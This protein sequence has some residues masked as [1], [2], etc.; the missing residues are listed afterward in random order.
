METLK[1]NLV[2]KNKTRT[3]LSRNSFNDFKVII[4]TFQESPYYIFN[5]FLLVT[6]SCSTWKRFIHV[7]KNSQDLR[8]R[9]RITLSILRVNY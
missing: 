7:R 6:S 4:Y 3:L 1:K 8:K 2:S 5:R 9:S